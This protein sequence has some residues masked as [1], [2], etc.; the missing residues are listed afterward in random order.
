MKKEITIGKDTHTVEA[1]K[2]GV[3]IKNRFDGSII[4]PSSWT[5]LRNAVIK[6]GADPTGCNF[7]MGRDNESYEALY[8]ALKTIKWNEKTGSYFTQ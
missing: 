2:V 1:K 7:F 5:T 4:F 6:L 8:K 3:A